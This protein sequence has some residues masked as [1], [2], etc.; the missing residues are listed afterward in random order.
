MHVVFLR[1]CAARHFKRYSDCSSRI[2]YKFQPRHGYKLS[3]K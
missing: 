3:G 1:V 2:H